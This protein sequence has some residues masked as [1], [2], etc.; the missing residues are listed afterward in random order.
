MLSSGFLKYEIFHNTVL[1]YA[2]GLLLF[3]AG[4]ALV[5]V[6][7][8]I[9]SNRF[10]AWAEKTATTLDDF[11]LQAFEKSAVPLFYYGAF[12]FALS[13]LVLPPSLR[14]GLALLTTVV[15]TVCAVQFVVELVASL[16]N[17]YWLKKE[18][19]SSREQVVKGLLPFLKTLIWGLGAVFLLDNLGYKVSTVLAGLGIGGVAVA[20][21]AQAILGDLFSYFAILFDRPFVIGDFIVVDDAMGTIEHIGIK[22][23]RVRSLSGEQLV[24]SNSSLTAS[25]IRNYKRMEQRRVLQ[26]ISVAY[27]TPTP[28]LK[29]IPE[30]LKA[31][32]SPRK[33]V[34]FDRAHLCAFSDFSIDFELVYYVLSG[35]YNQHMDIQ[36]EILLA[37]KEYFDRRGI[38]IPFPTQ[39][40]FV[41][42]TA[43]GA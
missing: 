25:C 14:K 20:L 6:V 1:S 32:V 39:T 34:R 33:D 13:G 9:V 43:G 16:L 5:R 38:E 29:E 19:G 12:Y 2:T 11:L 7:R 42:K 40:L 21:A 10:K 24:F 30:M 31:I 18:R 36:Q 3:L 22:T 8:A 26:K 15:L 4:V 17:E 23:T 27:A 37:V 35:D 28:Q 41:K